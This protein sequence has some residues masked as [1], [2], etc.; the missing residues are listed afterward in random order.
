[1]GSAHACKPR[2]DRSDTSQ[3]PP[4]HLSIP[5]WVRGHGRCTRLPQSPTP[6]TQLTTL[7]GTGSVHFFRLTLYLP[8][9]GH[10][11]S[12]PMSQSTW[13]SLIIFP[14]F[15]F[16][17]WTTTNALRMQPS[18]VLTLTGLLFLCSHVIPEVTSLDLYGDLCELDES[19]TCRRELGDQPPE[20]V[21]ICER[22]GLYWANV[23]GFSY[24]CQCSQKVFHYCYLAVVGY[25]G[26]NEDPFGR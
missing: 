12:L 10:N 16:Q 21:Q 25:S 2:D 1:M 23:P 19:Y 7:A 4:G 22:C 9:K 3:R 5:F 24:C 26:D 6:V 18:L 8:R 15:S 11:N 13:W 14:P 20:L 17:M